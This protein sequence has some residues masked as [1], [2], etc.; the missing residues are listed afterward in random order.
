M[1]LFNLYYNIVGLGTWI[2][3]GKPETTTMLINKKK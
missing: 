1:K 3:E 2:L